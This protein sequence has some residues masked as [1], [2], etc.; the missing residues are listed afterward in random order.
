MLRKTYNDDELRAK[1]ERYC[2]QEERC[3]ATVSQKL[4][5]WGASTQLAEHIVQHLVDGGF[6]DEHRYVRL[7][8]Q[9]KLRIQHWGRNKMAWELRGKGIDATLVEE[10]LASLDEEEY[11]AVLD[12]VAQSKYATLH[13][14]NDYDNRCRLTAFLLSRGFTADEIRQWSA[15]LK[16]K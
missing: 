16:R 6:I 9:G 12:K 4:R 8:C 15:D 2:A 7:F 1:A 5:E 14:D 11:L 10:G 13:S 3:V